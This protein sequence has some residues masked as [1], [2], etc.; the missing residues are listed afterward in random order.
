M[1]LPHS[2]PSQ[3]WFE[4]HF[5]TVQLQ[6]SDQTS[7]NSQYWAIVLQSAPLPDKV[8]AAEPTLGKYLGGGL[9]KKHFFK[10]KK[11]KNLFVSKVL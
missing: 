10:G 2:C 11:A 7:P 4:V 6:L 9:Y 5:K 8:S 1:Q 3:L